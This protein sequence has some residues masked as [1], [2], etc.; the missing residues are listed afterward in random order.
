MNES[1]KVWINESMNNDVRLMIENIIKEHNC[2]NK[3]Q[4]SEWINNWINDT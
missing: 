1:M 3:K 2:V 4:I